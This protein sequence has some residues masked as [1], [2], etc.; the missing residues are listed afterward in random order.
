MK[1]LTNKAFHNAVSKEANTIRENEELRRTMMDFRER[2]SKLE[3][4]VRMLEQR[5]DGNK[6]CVPNC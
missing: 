4:Q 5:E 1:I 2:I 6:T 3:F